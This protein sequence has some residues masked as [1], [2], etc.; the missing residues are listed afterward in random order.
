MAPA[1]SVERLGGLALRGADLLG[2]LDVEVVGLLEI[3]SARRAALL[4]EIW[5]ARRAAF[6][7][8][9]LARAKAAAA[10]FHS[11]SSASRAAC[12]RPAKYPSSSSARS[13]LSHHFL[14]PQKLAFA[15][16]VGDVFRPAATFIQETPGGDEFLDA[17]PQIQSRLAAATTP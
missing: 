5:S 7:A 14:P 8:G 17:I 16:G 12:T 11:F 1:C 4:A 15:S 9:N 6:R 13:T 10:A 2:D 3:W